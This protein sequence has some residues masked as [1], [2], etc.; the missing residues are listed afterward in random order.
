MKYAAKIEQWFA[1]CKAELP[2]EN[3]SRSCHNAFPNDIEKLS[4]GCTARTRLAVRS[5][6]AL[7]DDSIFSNYGS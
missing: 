3:W 5:L 4:L 7:G 2:F 1:D 6:T